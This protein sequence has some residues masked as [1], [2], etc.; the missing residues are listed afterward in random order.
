MVFYVRDEDMI[1]R[2][3]G[4][5]VAFC[6]EGLS[7]SHHSKWDST[8]FPVTVTVAAEQGTTSL[9]PGGCFFFLSFFKVNNPAVIEII[10]AASS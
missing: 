1:P 6:A 7:G 2:E 5:V 4:M 9:G 3:K 8:L 10:S